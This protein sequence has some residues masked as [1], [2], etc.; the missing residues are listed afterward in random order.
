MFTAIAQT[1]YA[2]ITW[3]LW[4]IFGVLYWI[5]Y[6]ILWAIDLLKY[7]L[8]PYVLGTI[9][10]ICY[11][12][13]YFRITEKDIQRVLHPTPVDKIAATD[14]EVIYTAP[15]DIL[16]AFTSHFLGN[17]DTKQ[18][19]MYGEND[20]INHNYYKGKIVAIAGV[21]ICPAN[22]ETLCKYATKII[23]VTP[24]P[25]YK[26]PPLKSHIDS[27]KLQLINRHVELWKFATHPLT[28]APQTPIILCYLDR[29]D[30]KFG[31]YIREYVYSVL[32]WRRPNLGD[33]PAKAIADLMTHTGLTL[34]DV[35]TLHTP[36]EHRLPKPLY[37]MSKII[38][39]GKATYDL[40]CLIAQQTPAHVTVNTDIYGAK[41]TMYSYITTAALVNAT[42]GVALK[43]IQDAQAAMSTTTP[44]NPFVVCIFCFDVHAQQ[45]IAT[46]VTSKHNN[47]LP[48]LGLT[49]YPF[50]LS[51]I[52]IAYKTPPQFLS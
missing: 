28:P 3:L 5:A 25:Y 12:V 48:L 21:D 46:Y 20:I 18:F 31:A 13:Y 1:I 30:L 7:P 19:H 49:T 2:A 11:A 26:H 10:A 35:E 34:A 40:K 9:A 42:L 16:G 29:P 4:A 41:V 37:D 33:A 27:G 43:D 15:F 38:K 24:H 14:V 47:I 39:T 44:Q 8:H 52:R 6:A 22:L 32:E 50:D 51:T 23:L 17:K 45:W 36:T